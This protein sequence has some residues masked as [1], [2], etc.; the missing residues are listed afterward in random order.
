MTSYQYD[1]TDY[2]ISTQRV[3]GSYVADKLAENDDVVVVDVEMSFP[4]SDTWEKLLPLERPLVHFEI[5]DDPEMR[6]GFGVA[7]TIED[8]PG[9]TVVISEPALHE[10]NF[11]V[12]IWTSVQSGGPVKRTQIRQ[13]LY[14]IFGPAGAR[15]QFTQDTG[16]VVKS[17]GG[18]N[19]VLDRVGDV[20]V[21]RTTSGT[22]IV[23]VFSKHTRQDPVGVVLT[24]DQE[25][26]LSIE[27]A[28]GSL[29]HVS[30]DEDPW[31]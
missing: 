17:F 28:D 12:G 4:G 23:S 10:I 9:D 8:S 6:L 31:S 19:D 13:A 16:I 7:Q 3:L 20:P 25:Q 1:P 5:D 21:Y 29:H 24:F 14:S 11:D 22:L 18:G 15:Q 2:L 26:K 27:G 30:T